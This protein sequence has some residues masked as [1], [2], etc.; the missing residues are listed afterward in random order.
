M[1]NVV[2]RPT[3]NKLFVE[4][5]IADIHFGAINPNLQYNILKEQFLD[6][7]SSMETLDI[8]SIDGDIFEHKY[9]ANS[10][11]V[12]YACYFMEELVRICRM[13][14]TTLIIIGGT[15][16]HDADQLKLFYKYANVNSE[17]DVRIIEE[18]RFEYIK[19]KKILIIPELYAKGKEYYEKFLFHS[20]LYDALYMHGTLVNTVYGKTTPSLDSARDPVFCIE[21][22]INCAGPIIAGH[23][24][25]PGCHGMYFYYCGTPIRCKFGQEEDKGYL[26]LLH[27]ID[28]REHYTYFKTVKSFRYDT[29]NLD[30]MIEQDPKIVI[31][32]INN[33]Q[34][35]GIDNIRV[36]ITKNISENINVVRNYYR[37]N[38]NVKIEADFKN[39]KVLQ[40]IKILSEKYNDYEY[41]KGPGT[42][43][44][45]LAQY[46]NQNEGCI[47]ITADELK[48]L[49]KNL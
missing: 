38:P 48:A 16:E 27:N 30:N 34:A 42:P 23:V 13:K 21:D 7:I 25:T 6:V 14:N 31:D 22:F 36:E 49:L 19:G 9:M 26:I 8:V 33:L 44:S 24:H 28:T 35:N 2:E 39:D 4:V 41:L 1:I 17:A 3:I 47:F 32:Y 11:A 18:V 37:S 5:H 29:I 20:G 15:Y 45:K 40:D 46:I 10:N 12:M 43:E